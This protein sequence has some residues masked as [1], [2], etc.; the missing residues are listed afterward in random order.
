MKDITSDYKLRKARN[1]DQEYTD[2]IL[3]SDTGTIL[4]EKLGSD[5]NDNGP[6]CEPD[7]FISVLCCSVILTARVISSAYNSAYTGC[8]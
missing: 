2:L 6:I 4:T 7:L 5:I 1:C 3:G 8:I